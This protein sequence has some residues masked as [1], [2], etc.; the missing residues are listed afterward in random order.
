MEKLTMDSLESFAG[1]EE[2]GKEL[3]TR[4][5]LLPLGEF[6]SCAARAW[7]SRWKNEMRGGAKGLYRAW[8]SQIPHKLG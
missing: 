7:F 8:G 1:A 2:Q 5:G 6:Q 3:T 4:G